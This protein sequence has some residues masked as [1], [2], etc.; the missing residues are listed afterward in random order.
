MTIYG[1]TL[2][3]FK[4]G[5]NDCSRNG[6]KTKLHKIKILVFLSLG[7]VVEKRTLL[8]C[9]CFFLSLKVWVAMRFTAKTR[10]CYAKFQP[11]LHEAVDGRTND[12][13]RTKI[14]WMQIFG[15][16]DNEFFYQWYSA[17]APRGSGENHHSVVS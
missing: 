12:F 1:Q 14:S 15:C 10:G 16:I 8:C 11:S 5:N 7:C 3:V 9:C 4:R 13:V 2:G 17:K 6:V